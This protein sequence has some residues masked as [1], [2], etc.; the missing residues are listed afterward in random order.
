MGFGAGA[1]ISSI[2]YEL[3]PESLSGGLPMALAFALGA[4]VFFV[5]DWWIDKRGG[6]ERKSIK[7]EA[8]DSGTT[9]FL[10]SLLDGIPESLILGIGMGLG[11]GI[12]LAF[13]LAVFLEPARG[14]GRN[15]QSR[16]G[17]ALE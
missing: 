6:G 11:G 12:S 4:V 16:T 17:R 10:G 1:L 8:T 14:H 3:V 5:S 7:G 2:S 9:I 13:L 15:H